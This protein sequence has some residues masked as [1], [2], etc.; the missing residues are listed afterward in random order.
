MKQKE[1]KNQ[2][3]VILNNSYVSSE[4]LILHQLMISSIILTTRLLDIV[5]ILW[6]ESLPW[7]PMRVKG[8]TVSLLSIAL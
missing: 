8:L 7:S 2:F 6:G 5:L 4:N 3:K 1:T